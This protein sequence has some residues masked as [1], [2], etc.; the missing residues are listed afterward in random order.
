MRMTRREFVDELQKRTEE[1][2]GYRWSKADCDNMITIFSQTVMESLAENRT[3]QI[4]GFGEFTYRLRPAINC[5]H[6]ATKEDI[7]I[8][9][10]PLPFFKAS[11]QFKRM[12]KEVQI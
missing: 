5:K 7:H 12:V 4:K 6:P 8:P 10:C 2:T 9:A 11:E 1:V 3:V